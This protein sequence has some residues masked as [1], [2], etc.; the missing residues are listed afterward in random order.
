M[1]TVSLDEF[2]SWL[3]AHVNC[4][5]R[6]GTPETM[7]FDDEDLHWHLDDFEGL[8]VLQTVRGKRLMGEILIDPVRVGFVRETDSERPDEFCFE[9]VMQEDGNE[10]V[11]YMVYLIHGWDEAP[12]PQ[13]GRV[14]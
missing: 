9:M 12:V 6:A 14:H 1:V 11:E 10:Y 2:W 3:H 13:R 5:L 4:I 7:V 8:R